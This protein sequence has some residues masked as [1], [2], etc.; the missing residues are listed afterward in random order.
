[1]P[2]V[3]IK[4]QAIRPANPRYPEDVF[5]RLE[6]NF[7]NA[8]MGPVLHILTGAM[9]LRTLGWRTSPSF[10]SVFNT[11]ASHLGLTGFSMTVKPEGRA[12][13]LWGYVSLG[14]KARKIV[15]RRKHMLFIRG[16][17]GGYMPRTG[18]NGLYGGP[19]AYVGS[20]FW[21]R[22]VNW[23]GIQP[24]AFEADIVKQHEGEI[25]GILTQAWEASING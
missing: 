15:P 14:V 7:T 9:V 6:L 10:G 16:G 22:S 1:M 21:T 25:V 5:D 19:G 17:V 12:A 13:T 2:R 8:L 18:P 23:P 3:Q 20:G 11:R 4:F 24:R